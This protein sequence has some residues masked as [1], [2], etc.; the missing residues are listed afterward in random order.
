MPIER[1]PKSNKVAKAVSDGQASVP[2]SEDCFVV[3]KFKD[4][5]ASV[6]RKKTKSLFANIWYEGELC[7]LFAPTNVGKTILAVQIAETIASGREIG[8]FS[9]DLD[10][11][12]VLF[13]NL[14]LGDKQLMHRYADPYNE[15][16]YDWSDNM[17]LF[18]IDF[19]KMRKRLKN[20]AAFQEYL[21]EQIFA[22]AQQVGA[23]VIIIDNLMMLGSELEKATNATLLLVRLKAIKEEL[24]LSVLCIAHTPKKDKGQGL[25]INN[26]AGSANIA[27]WL[28]SCCAVGNSQKDESLRYIIQLKCR[29]PEFTYGYSNVAVCRVAI[30]NDFIHFDF[31]NT[32]HEDELLKRPD[33]DEKAEQFAKQS[34][35]EQL[36]LT[37]IQEIRTQQETLGLKPLSSRMMA[38]ALFKKGVKTNHNTVANLVKRYITDIPSTPNTPSEGSADELPF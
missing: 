26:L 11:T 15:T 29:E 7:V 9:S 28:D 18:T 38:E 8:G 31:L 36:I 27:G 17:N 35:K 12:P 1:K 2:A 20:W 37:A 13:V 32:M 33:E 19:A 34:E 21:F 10:A 23:K 24:G 25:T 30:T 16:S 5:A 6:D 14:E 4:V 22:R 3:R